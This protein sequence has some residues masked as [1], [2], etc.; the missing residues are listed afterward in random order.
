[1]RN[2]EGGMENA[3]YFKIYDSVVLPN[4]PFLQHSNTPADYLCPAHLN[5]IEFQKI[6]V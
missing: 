3:E 5:E 1:M 2:A 6:T 4:T